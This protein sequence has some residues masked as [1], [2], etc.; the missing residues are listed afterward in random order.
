MNVFL[1]NKRFKIVVFDLDGTLYHRKHYMSQYYYLARRG[2]KDLCQ[3]SNG[4]IEQALARNSISEDFRLPQGSVTGMF[5]S[6]G[7][8]VQEWNQYRNENLDL[9]KGLMPNERLTNVLYWL[10]KKYTLAIATN[11]TAI[12]TDSILRGLELPKHLFSTIITS[13]SGLKPKPS[14]DL[15]YWLEAKYKI[16]FNEFL[17]FGDR[18]ELDIEPLILLGGSGVLIYTPEEIIDFAESNLRS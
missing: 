8:S 2:L 12:L 11:S 16:E 1:H 5:L 3:M 14:P 18:Y 13:D 7:I 17:A 10:A 15:F 6:L 9:E 4:E